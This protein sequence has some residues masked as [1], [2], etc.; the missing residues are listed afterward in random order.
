MMLTKHQ[1]ESSQ[2]EYEVN[3]PKAPFKVCGDGAQIQQCLM[4]LIFNAIESMP[5]GGKLTINGGVENGKDIVWLSVA[6]NGHGI[7]PEDLPHIFEPFYSTKVD[8]KGVGL[9]LSMTYGIIR[10]H[11]GVVEVDSKPG[12]GTV[13]KIR[14]PRSSPDQRDYADVKSVSSAI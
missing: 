4:N 8:G 5:E 12:K 10:E 1:L 13:F 7:K 11:N 3:L 2:V 14:L 9:G 6:D